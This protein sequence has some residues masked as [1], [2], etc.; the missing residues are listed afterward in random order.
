MTAQTEVY[1]LF[2]QV[3]HLHF[4]MKG[5]FFQMVAEAE[6]EPEGIHFI[7]R[8]IAFQDKGNR[9]FFP[10]L[11]GEF[12]RGSKAVDGQVIGFAPV[13][14]AAIGESCHIG[15]DIGCP[16]RPVSG[17]SLPQIF[18]AVC[19]ADAHEF[20]TGIGNGHLKPVIFNMSQHMEKPPAIVWNRW[21]L[22][23]LFY[24]FPAGY[25]M[26]DCICTRDKMYKK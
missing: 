22:I 26:A 19:R 16:V 8:F 13:S 14:V 9:G 15:E 20:C 25:A 10:I 3:F 12:C 21:V 5:I 17:I 18:G 7:E 1:G 11:R 6:P 23:P 2:V 24:R 4:H